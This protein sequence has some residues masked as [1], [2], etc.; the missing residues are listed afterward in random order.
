MDFE[1]ASDPEKSSGFL[2]ISSPAYDIFTGHIVYPISPSARTAIS[3]FKFIRYILGDNK[4]TQDGKRYKC[5]KCNELVYPKRG[6][7]KRWYFAHYPHS[8]CMD[9]TIKLH[10]DGESNNHKLA[11]YMLYDLLLNKIPINIL[12]CKCSNS[13]CANRNH[14]TNIQY[15]ITDEIKLEYKFS[16]GDLRCDVA[17]LGCIQYLFEVYNTSKTKTMRIDPWFEIHA[18]EIIQKYENGDFNLIYL[19]DI[20]HY[21]CDN[22][23]QEE[24][25]YKNLVISNTCDNIKRI[26]N[27]QINK[28]DKESIYK[29]TNI[30]EIAQT[31]GF[32]TIKKGYPCYSLRLLDEVTTGWYTMDKEECLCYFFYICIFIY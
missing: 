30:K 27:I 26:T 32:M 11:K 15:S 25:N 3:N 12:G 19:H 23:D 5:L 7:I 8:K 31:L 18:K 29:N 9:E 13:Y 21:L 28:K 6:T 4:S 22:C 16:T 17:L 14:D 1:I 24:R 2:E 20:K 10:G